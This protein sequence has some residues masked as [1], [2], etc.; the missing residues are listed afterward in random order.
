MGEEVREEEG[1]EV[2]QDV[3][4]ETMTCCWF[5][6]PINTITK[7]TTVSNFPYS[8]LNSDRTSGH[9]QIYPSRAW[10]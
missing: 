4:S 5:P 7:K 6:P 9:G 10:V 3:K 1:G 8:G 2:G